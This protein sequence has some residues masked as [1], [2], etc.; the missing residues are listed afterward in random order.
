MS[1]KLSLP[2]VAALLAGAPALA[3]EIAPPGPPA[4]AAEGLFVE[5][6]T[7]LDLGSTGASLAG[8]EW[9][10]SSVGLRLGV[11]RRGPGA[12]C[13]VRFKGFASGEKEFT[14]EDLNIDAKGRSSGIALDGYAG[15]GWA[16][17]RSWLLSASGGLGFRA[18]QAGFTTE[19]VLGQKV[20]VEVSARALTLDLGLRLDAALN[21]R[22][23]WNFSLLGGPVIAG[24]VT[25][26]AQWFLLS[27]KHTEN[28]EAG[29]FFELRTGLDVKVGRNAYLELGLAL[30]AFAVD[31]NLDNDDDLDGLA[32]SQAAFTVGLNWKF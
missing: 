17:G 13:G 6:E 3:G 11:G 29:V 4:P 25:A 14:Q 10:G 9:S 18:Y 1:W 5:V 26:D 12:N 23:K 21:E 19:E 2:L 32:I 31:A 20:D 16:L 24:E 28:I 7:G 22:L 15:W 30:E 27:Y 8:T